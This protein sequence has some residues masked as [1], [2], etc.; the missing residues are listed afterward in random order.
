MAVGGWKMARKRIEPGEAVHTGVTRDAAGNLWWF[1][2]PR[3]A[4][5]GGPLPD[6]VEFHGPFQTD[7]ECAEDERRVLLGPDCEAK[8]AGMWDKAWEKPQ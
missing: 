1:V 8:A 2:V 6:G 4:V 5:A 7:A 3:D